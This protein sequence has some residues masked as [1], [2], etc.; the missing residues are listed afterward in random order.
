M[1]M[2][3]NKMTCPKCQSDKVIKFGFS[4]GRQRYGCN[5]CGHVFVMKTIKGR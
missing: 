5:S 4:L 1:T 2:E 3:L